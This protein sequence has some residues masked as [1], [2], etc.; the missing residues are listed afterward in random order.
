MNSSE[1]QSDKLS[2][3]KKKVKFILKKKVIILFTFFLNKYCLVNY[4]KLN[5][6]KT[7]RKDKRKLHRQLLRAETKKTMTEIQFN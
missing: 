6:K 4:L 2:D 5:K 3:S 7:N 1:D